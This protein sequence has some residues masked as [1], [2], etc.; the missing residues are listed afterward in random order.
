MDC[1]AHV[2]LA[3]P[4]QAQEAVQSQYPQLEE[5]AKQ[6]LAQE[7]EECSRGNDEKWAGPGG[8][9]STYFNHTVGWS[10]R[11]GPSFVLVSH[12]LARLAA[13]G[14]VT[15]QRW[16]EREGGIEGGWGWAAG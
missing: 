15:W 11:F 5:A 6:R 13:R 7:A 16:E 4:D 1:S 14:R 2:P 10:W 3:S 12:F 8:L 9:I